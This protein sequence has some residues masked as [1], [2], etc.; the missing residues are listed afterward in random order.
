[1]AKVKYDPN[2]L[3]LPVPDSGL[4]AIAWDLGDVL[5]RLKESALRS[6]VSRMNRMTGANIRYSE[7]RAAIQQEWQNR[8]SPEAEQQIKAVKTEQDEQ[9]Y[10][11]GFYRCVLEIL[12]VES[13]LEDLMMSFAKM[14]MSPSCFE[15]TPGAR[16]TLE[17]FKKASIPQILISNS[18]PS[19]EAIVEYLDLVD[20][21]THI[22]MSHEGSSLKPEPD[23]YLRA[24]NTARIAPEETLFVDDRKLFVEGARKI[25][26]PALWLNKS[27]KSNSKTQI[28]KVKDVIPFAGF[29]RSQNA[30]LQ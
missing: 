19:A 17:E 7:L 1:M 23:I 21:F 3:Y 27:G 2:Q 6:A 14:Q 5:V 12:G 29:C 18:F 13:T 22:E 10:W 9:R 8:K 4:K 25:G 15:C 11:T 26:M 30:V 20:Y 16:E 28:N 24:L